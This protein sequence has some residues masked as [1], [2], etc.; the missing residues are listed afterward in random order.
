M[1]DGDIA[2]GPATVLYSDSRGP[3]PEKTVK[4][5]VLA[6]VILPSLDPPKRLSFDA[7]VNEIVREV[8]RLRKENLPWLVNMGA[9][10]IPATSTAAITSTLNLDGNFLQGYEGLP[11]TL[12]EIARSRA[13]TGTQVYDALAYLSGLRRLRGLGINSP[14]IQRTD[15]DLPGWIDGSKKVTMRVGGRDIAPDILREIRRAEDLFPSVTRDPV[16]G[17]GNLADSVAIR[18]FLYE[19]AHPGRKVA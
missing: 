3:R 7:R 18:N 6:Y 10:T 1:T 2:L 13:G 19:A 16:R 14:V 9:L 4:E 15:G 8:P 5:A 17:K 12:D 11:V